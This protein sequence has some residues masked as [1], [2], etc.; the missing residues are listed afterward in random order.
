LDLAKEAYASAYNRQDELCAPYATVID[1][2]PAR[3]PAPGEVRRWS[4]EQYAG[5]LRHDAANPLYNPNLRQ[6][7]HVAYKVA[8]EMGARY[9][10]MLD[11]CE[12][13]VSRNVTE[14]LFDRHIM[15]LFLGN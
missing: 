5:A 15:P 14:N 1:I 13:A 3:L 9:T 6:L 12:E 2:D 10:D 8:A 4:S 7:L 11:A